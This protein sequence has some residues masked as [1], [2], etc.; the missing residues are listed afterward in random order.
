[1]CL[2]A[3]PVLVWERLL[4]VLNTNQI[5]RRDMLGGQWLIEVLRFGVQSLGAPEMPI[6]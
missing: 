1:M 3:V 6:R 4:Q 2:L 5:L